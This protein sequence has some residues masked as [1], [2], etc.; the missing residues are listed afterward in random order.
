[1]R[2]ERTLVLLK[3]DCVDRGLVGEAISRIERKGLRIVAMRMIVLDR[4]TAEKHY[5]AHKDKPF[6]EGVVQYI[7]AGP[8]MALAVE[9]P[10]AIEVLRRLCGSTDGAEAAAGT[11]RGDFSLS[12]AFNLIHASD[13]AQSASR[14]LDLFFEPGDFLS[15]PPVKWQA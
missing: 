10:R 7:T 12:V 5:A 8:I 2:P 13:S 14:E 6:F 9:G 11:I 1:M 15:L 4:A 3:P